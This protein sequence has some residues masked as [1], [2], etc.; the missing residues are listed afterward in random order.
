MEAQKGLHHV[1]TRPMNPMNYPDR[2]QPSSDV[3]PT[4]RPSGAIAEDGSWRFRQRQSRGTK[5]IHKWYHG[6]VWHLWHVQHHLLRRQVRRETYNKICLVRFLDSHEID[7]ICLH[8]PAVHCVWCKYVKAAVLP[9]V[10]FLWTL[11]GMMS[12]Q[13]FLLFCGNPCVCQL[14]VGWPYHQTVSRCIETYLLESIWQSQY[15]LVIKHDKWRTP[16]SR[17]HDSSHHQPSN[18][19]SMASTQ[20]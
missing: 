14:S 6:H 18:V 11:S 16:F 8:F 7:K 17:D 10:D 13:R 20:G 2:S 9:W 12:L 4:G 15:I 3:V 5:W 19:H 1:C